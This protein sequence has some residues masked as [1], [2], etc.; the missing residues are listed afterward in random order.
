[1]EIRGFTI[2]RQAMKFAVFDNGQPASKVGYPQC[3]SWGNHVF[4]T[5]LEA[6]DYAIKWLGD[7]GIGVTLQINTPYDYD[8][9]GD[10]IEIRKTE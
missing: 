8:G 3:G 4:P 9:Y 5:L 1:V 2:R 6:H 10:L 7:F